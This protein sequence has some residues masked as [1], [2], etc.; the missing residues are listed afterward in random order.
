MDDLEKIKLDIKNT[1]GKTIST[2]Q[3]FP[4]TY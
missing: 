4:R 1:I 3:R 2:R